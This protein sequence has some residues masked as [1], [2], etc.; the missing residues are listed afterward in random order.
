[1]YLSLLSG[2]ASTG[3]TQ[4]LTDAG[5]IFTQFVSWIN[6][7]LGVI[8]ENEVLWIP[9]AIGLIGSAFGILS[10]IFHRG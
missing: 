1:M 4:L 9:I 3:L 10:R 6:T 2:T 5:A 7:G 8:L